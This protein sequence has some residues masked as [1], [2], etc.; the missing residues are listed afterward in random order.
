M[1]TPQSF[2]PTPGARSFVMARST[3][4]AEDVLFLARD[5]LRVEQAVTSTNSKTR[6]VAAQ[7]KQQ[8][9]LA[10]FNAQDTGNGITLTCGQHVASK[11]GNTLYCSTRSMVPAMRN[12]Y[13]YFELSVGADAT[14]GDRGGMASLSIGLSTQEMPLNT[15]VGSWKGSVGLCTNGQIL[16]A[17]R[18]S[19]TDSTRLAS[20]GHECTVGVLV[21]IDDDSE[22]M[23]WDGEMVNAKVAFS[24]NGNAVR[25]LE[26]PHAPRGG[27]WKRRNRSRGRGR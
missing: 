5:Q 20:Y 11:T 4:F 25:S 17:G 18:W 15:L 27:G 3:Q 9:R 14:G 21:Y 2:P 8:S 19:S 10:V 12:C 23:T 22:F 26:T 1:C 7:L 16:D 6:A 13:V 24:V